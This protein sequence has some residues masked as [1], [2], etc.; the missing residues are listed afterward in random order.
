LVRERAQGLGITWLAVVARDEVL[1]LKLLPR[2]EL[3]RPEQRDEIVQLAQVVLE[4]R[5][6][7]QEDEVP[8][9]FL[10]ELVGRAAV[11][12][13]LVR[14]V[15]D[16]QVPAVPQDLLGVAARARSVVRDDR[17]GDGKALPVVGL[18]RGLEV[19]EELLFELALPLAHERGGR[20]DQRAA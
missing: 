4:R 14:L 11:T 8:L 15:H 17:P 5:S 9:D 18:G 3:A 13:Y 12:L 19:L 16:H 20:Q 7:E 2:A 1:A 6:G 10:N